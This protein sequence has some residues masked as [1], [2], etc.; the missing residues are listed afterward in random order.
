MHG[1]GRQLAGAPEVGHRVAEVRAA[2]NDAV[3]VAHRV[4]YD[5]LVT[6]RLLIWLATNPDGTPMS[7]EELLG[8]PGG[9]Q[10]ALF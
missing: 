2:L 8:E 6:A 1:M 3:L 9:H 5:I 7:A 10:D 4:T